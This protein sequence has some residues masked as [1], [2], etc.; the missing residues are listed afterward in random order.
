MIAFPGAIRQITSSRKFLG[1]GGGDY[2]IPGGVMNGQTA[3]LFVDTQASGNQK[4]KHHPSPTQC[5]GTEVMF[6]ELTES[7]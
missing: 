5:R 4:G 2:S 7:N 1:G 3:P 6:T